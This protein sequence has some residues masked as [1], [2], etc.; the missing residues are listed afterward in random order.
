MLL[1]AKSGTL[2]LCS[3]QT[4]VQRTRVIFRTDDAPVSALSSRTKQAASAPVRECVSLWLVISVPGLHHV[5][6]T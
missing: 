1:L 4:V 2:T 3:R 6:L 5:S